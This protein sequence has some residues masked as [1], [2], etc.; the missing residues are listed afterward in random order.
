MCKENVVGSK[1]ITCKAE[2]NA[3][4]PG[5]IGKKTCKWQINFWPKNRF[6]QWHSNFCPKNCSE[7]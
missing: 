2:H 6:G 3:G 4:F 5:C 7:A 1:C